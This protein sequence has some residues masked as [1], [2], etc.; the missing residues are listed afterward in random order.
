MINTDLRP[1]DTEETLPAYS[2]DDDDSS[3]SPATTP[4]P[5]S[6]TLSDDEVVNHLTADTD[7]DVKED[8]DEMA[9][10]STLN[11]DSAGITDFTTI[12]KSLGFGNTAWGSG[13]STNP[14]HLEFG[15]DH[16]HGHRHSSP[17]STATDIPL[18]PSDIDSDDRPSGRLP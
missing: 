15:L 4:T 12:G 3:A 13:V 11:M 10:S 5:P 17:A 1:V 8:D 6:P 14:V 7:T 18:S 2:P 16:G 9:S